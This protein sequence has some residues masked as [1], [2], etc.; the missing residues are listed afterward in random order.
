[1]KYKVKRFSEFINNEMLAWEFIND[2]ISKKNSTS[3]P[4]NEVSQEIL[5]S[6]KYFD[7]ISK[8]KIAFYGIHEYLYGILMSFFSTRDR[9]QEKVGLGDKYKKLIN[10]STSDSINFGVWDVIARGE[11][12]YREVC[13][14]PE[15]FIGIHEFSVLYPK[16]RWTFPNELRSDFSI[17]E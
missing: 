1:M 11:K 6:S 15:L 16:D 2:C 17:N 8:I 10:T 7:E 14:N 5:Q 9:I 4:S 12:F 13:E 3:L